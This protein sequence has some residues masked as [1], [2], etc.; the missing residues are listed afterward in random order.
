MAG[1]IDKDQQAA[2]EAALNNQYFVLQ[3]A[4]GTTIT[5]S[6]NRASLFVLALSSTLVA[7]GFVGPSKG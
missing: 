2:F 5:E 7:I 4:R 3:A 1:M 6:G